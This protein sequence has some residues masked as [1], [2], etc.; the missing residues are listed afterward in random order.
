ML[1]K[2]I[3][4]DWISIVKTSSNFVWFTI[5]KR[6]TKAT[7]D[8]YVCGLYIPPSS[9]KY[10]DP[11]LFEELNFSSQ[12]SILLLGDFNSRTGKYSD[13]VCHD[14]NNSIVN[15]QSESSFY[16]IRRNSYENEINNH[17]KRL[18]DICKSAEL[19][20]LNGRVWGDILGRPTFHGRNG[21]SV[22]DYAICD[23]GLF[24][25]VSNFIA[26]QPQIPPMQATKKLIN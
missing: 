19:K 21:I 20:I 24:S 1:Y 12:G 2:N 23:R 4:H 5:N 10:F 7:K 16:P 11:E 25:N 6:Y 17:G 9:S 8:I 26:S 15:D 22:I 13:S 18:L 14:G 3:F